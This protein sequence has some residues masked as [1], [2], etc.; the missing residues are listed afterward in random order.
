[1]GWKP[2]VVALATSLA[3][4]LAGLQIKALVHQRA[5]SACIAHLERLANEADSNPNPVV[6]PFQALPVNIENEYRPTTFG[7]KNREGEAILP[8]TFTQARAFME[9]KAAVAN[10]NWA[11]GF[12]DP[13]GQLVIPYQ[14]G[15]ISDFHDGVAAFSGVNG[16]KA[17]EGFIDKDGIIIVLLKSDGG[18]FVSDFLGFKNGH[19]QSNRWAWAP[20]HGNPRPVV[21]ISIDCT[22]KVTETK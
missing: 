2:L 21:N 13:E 16:D 22:G 7:Y 3:V 12:I 18:F 14:F 4:T 1:M 8:E 19:V 20:F 9:G 11:W 5:L 17:K 15:S 10:R 6:E